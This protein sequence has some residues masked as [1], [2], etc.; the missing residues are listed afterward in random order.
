MQRMTFSLLFSAL[1]SAADKVAVLGI[2][3]NRKRPIGNSHLR[4]KLRGL[5]ISAQGQEKRLS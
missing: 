1:A 5:P 3:F 2:V 4:P